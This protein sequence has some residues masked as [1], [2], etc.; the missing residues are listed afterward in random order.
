MFNL[1][2]ILL[3]I[4][5]FAL[6]SSVATI[7]KAYRKNRKEEKA[8]FLHH[9]EPEYDRNLFPQDQWCSDESHNNIQIR[10][11]LAKDRASGADGRY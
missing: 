6:I 10:V 4:G 9:F 2:N 5:A 1:T 8:P 7:V 11:R 3:T